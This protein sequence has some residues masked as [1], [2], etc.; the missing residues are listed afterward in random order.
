MDPLVEALEAFREKHNLSQE[1]LGGML[2]GY[3]QASYSNIANG[4]HKVSLALIKRVW[5]HLPGLR[6]AVLASLDS[7][8][9]VS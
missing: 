1:E 6:D 8:E 4:R 3:Q 2:G 7:E 5:H 9:E